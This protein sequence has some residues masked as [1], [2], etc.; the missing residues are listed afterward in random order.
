M[1]V[2]VCVCVYVCV[3][4]CATYHDDLL[5]LS[6]RYKGPFDAFWSILR[7]EGV[8]GLWKGWLPNI[9]RSAIVCL[10]GVVLYACH[11]HAQTHSG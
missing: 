1:C 6:G 7:T 8:R 4:V 3:C 10:G 2:S 11:T 5:P 9:T